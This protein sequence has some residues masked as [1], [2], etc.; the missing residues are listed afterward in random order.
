MGQ[1]ST[2]SVLEELEDLHRCM[3][4]A[5]PSDGMAASPFALPAEFRAKSPTMRRRE[6]HHHHGGSVV[7]EVSDARIARRGSKRAAAAA[8]AAECAVQKQGHNSPPPSPLRCNGLSPHKATAELRRDLAAR[9]RA[10]DALRREAADARRGFE[11]RLAE[12]DAASAT[13]RAE[14]IALR[15]ER[16]D[17]ATRLRAA[18]AAAASLESEAAAHAAALGA[19]LGEA[20]E[21]LAAARGLADEARRERDVLLA[22]ARSWQR[23]AAA[24]EDDAQA[25]RAAAAETGVR[26]RE[27]AEARQAAEAG[28]ERMRAEAEFLQEAKVSRGCNC[29]AA[30]SSETRH[31]KT[32]YTAADASHY[33]YQPRPSVSP[34]SKGHRGGRAAAAVARGA[35]RAQGVRALAARR[36]ADAGAQSVLCSFLSARLG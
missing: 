15:A 10:L 22:E 4:R 24:R 1:L 20:G 25:A 9:D 8:M 19:R 33:V 11:R 36:A 13:L 12:A 28:V 2:D 21:E 3:F 34:S 30:A 27:E 26:L 31:A 18:D 32:S 16:D 5:P 7:A 23:E 6:Y 17:L 35:Q 14:A 29:T